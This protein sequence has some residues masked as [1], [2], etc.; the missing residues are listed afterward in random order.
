MNLTLLYD[1]LVYSCD[2]YSPLEP[3]VKF[4]WLS[5]GRIFL[6]DSQE[7]KLVSVKLLAVELVD[8]VNMSF[9]L[10]GGL[11][12]GQSTFV[13]RERFKLPILYRTAVRRGKSNMELNFAI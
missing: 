2:H 10:L 7:D 9:G 13:W 11:L 12:D 8:P 1:V 3:T 6:S 4:V 5:S